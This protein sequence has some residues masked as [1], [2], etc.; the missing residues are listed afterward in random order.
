VDFWLYAS[1]N[2]DMTG[3][4]AQLLRQGTEVVV[5]INEID[6]DKQLRGCRRFLTTATLQA[7]QSG[8]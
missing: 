8:A 5:K 7:H 1:A 3:W 4:S 2:F 6:L